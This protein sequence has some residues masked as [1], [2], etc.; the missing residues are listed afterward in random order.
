MIAD[1]NP[2]ISWYALE[3]LALGQL[4]S[5][6]QEEIKTACHNHS[7][8]KQRQDF[9]AADTRPLPPFRPE[10]AQS[11]S[12]ATWP[13]LVWV[14][15]GALLLLWGVFLS[16]HHVFVPA[17]Q[18][19][20][21]Y[22]STKGGNLEVVAVR[23]RDDIS[24][25]APDT[26]SETDRFRF[27][28]TTPNARELSERVEVTVIQGNRIFFPYKRSLRINRG[29]LKGLPG[30]LQFTGTAPVE[31]CISTGKKIPGRNRIREH[32]IAAL[33]QSTVC[34]SLKYEPQ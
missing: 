4:S 12:W 6:R 22:D 8:L 29:N 3:R 23:L 15:A 19:R 34:I 1:P 16:L 14:S 9:I 25:H 31:V 27:Y 20:L 28:V 21:A 7:F 24:T 32:G 17:T 30:S 26:F 10:Q 18:T 13:Q 2:S 11:T 5:D 33:P